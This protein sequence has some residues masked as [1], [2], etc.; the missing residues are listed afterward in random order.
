MA[1]PKKGS[2][3]IIVDGI[4][5]RWRVRWKPTYSQSTCNSNLMAAVELYEN[6]Q[7][8]LSIEFPWIRYDAWIGVAEQPVTPSIIETCIKNALNQGWN[9]AEKS[10][11]F[12]FNYEK[13]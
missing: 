2:R 6:P 10:K 9:P 5:Y 3:K 13:E 12:K 1:I 7:N 11:T 8:I 4:E